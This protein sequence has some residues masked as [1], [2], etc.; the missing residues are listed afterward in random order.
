MH[1]AKTKISLKLSLMNQAVPLF[2]DKLLSA[3][4]YAAILTE[5]SSPLGSLMVAVYF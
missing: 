3:D 1:S 2:N 4:V 5:L